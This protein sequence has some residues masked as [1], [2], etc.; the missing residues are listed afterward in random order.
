MRRKLI[1]ALC[2]FAILASLCACKKTSAVSFTWNL[3]NG[4]AVEVELDTSESDMKLV[5]E[6]SRFRVEKDGNIIVRGGF[7]S[8]ETW[9]HYTEMYE[10]DNSAEVI[11]SDDNRFIW[12]F[13]G[14]DGLEYGM[15][16][17]VSDNTCVYAGNV[18]SDTATESLIREAF[19]RLTSHMDE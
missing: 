9:D 13:T 19:D 12:E 17:K 2:V 15:L 7:G 8:K 18:V 11:Y 4:E 3:A 10:Q 14:T 5:P 6:D 16:E 1:T